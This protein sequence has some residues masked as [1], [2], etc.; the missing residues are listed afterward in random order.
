MTLPEHIARCEREIEQCRE[1]A[2][3]ADNDLDRYGL[4]WAEVDW[5][6]AK[7][8]YENELAAAGGEARSNE[9]REGENGFRIG[10]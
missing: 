10:C 4:T 1:A 2:A 7:Q 3:M 6:V 8:L 5:L 9:D